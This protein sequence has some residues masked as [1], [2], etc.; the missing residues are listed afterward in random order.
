MD[1]DQFRKNRIKIKTLCENIEILATEKDAETSKKQLG[2][3]E[4]LLDDLAPQVEGEIQERSVK[5]LGMRL[6]AAS[7]LVDKIKQ[8]KKAGKPRKTTPVNLIKWDE[9]RLA[10]LP[11]NY[12]SKVYDHM[13]SLDATRIYFSTTGKGIKASYK[14]ESDNGSTSDFSGASHKPL[15]RKLPASGPK[16]S[17]PFPFSIIQ[18]IVQKK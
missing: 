3:A 9:E 4:S 11:E 18:T 14:I 12:L 7:M 2:Q 15:K 16:I 1:P 8:P 13:K 10:Q 6:N 17:S 5:N